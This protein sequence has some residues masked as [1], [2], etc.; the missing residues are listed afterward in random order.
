MKLKLNRNLALYKAGDIV[1]VE[2]VGGV[3][4]NGYW[5]RRLKDS[6][7]DNCVEIIEEK[8]VVRKKIAKDKKSEVLNDSQ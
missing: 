5:R 1:E 4:V 7:F 8:K 2:S 3:P 6:Q